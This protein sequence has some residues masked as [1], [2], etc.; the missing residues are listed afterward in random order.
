M[1]LFKGFCSLLSF[2]L[3]I[4]SFVIFVRIILSWV[5]LFSR[6]NGWRSGNGGYGY[7]Q[8]DPNNPSGLVRV[9]EILGRITDPYLNFF[10]GVK[11]L[12]LASLDLTPVLALVV[13]NLVRNLLGMIGSAGYINLWVIV[14][15]VIDSIWSLCSFLL[16]VLIITLVVRFF[17]GRSHSY[18]AV[19]FINT[20]DP[21]LDR[22]VGKVYSLFFKKKGEVEDEKLVIASIIFYVVLLVVCKALIGLLVS[23]LLSL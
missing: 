18:Q 8:E 10:S 1:N 17:V 5:L 21:I 16:V 3:G 7:A 22:P 2:V 15:F 4:Y 12:R 19:S 6:R 14:A 9:E 11:S 23:F 20:I 13:L